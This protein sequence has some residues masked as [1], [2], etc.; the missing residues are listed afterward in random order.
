MNKIIFNEA[1]FQVESYNKTTSFS[2]G[3]LNSNAYCSIITDDIDA[4]NALIGQS[5]NTI[6][7]YHDETLIYDLHNALGRIDNVNEYL[8]GDR[9]SINVNLSFGF[10]ATQG[11]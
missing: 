10:V 4:L 11:E 3:Q 8:S 2:E 5:I 7:I 9:M 6:Q 1:E